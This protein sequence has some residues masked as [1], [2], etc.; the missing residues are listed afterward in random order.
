YYQPP[1]PPPPP[2]HPAIGGSSMFSVS[3][4]KF[5]GSPTG[6]HPLYRGIRPR[7][8]KWVSEIREPKK[9]T[10]IWLGTWA[11]AEMAAAAYDAAALALKGTEAILNFPQDALRYPVPP[12]S[13]AADIRKAAATA[14]A[15]KQDKEKNSSTTTNADDLGLERVGKQG[16]E[17]EFIDIEAFF[18][19]PNLLVDMAG[20]MMVSPPRMSSTDDRDSPEN[21]DC[22]GEAGSLWSYD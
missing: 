19:M 2:P 20:G 15:M 10:R 3:P 18:N 9:T 13:S 5:I 6:K 7:G 11:T 12:S 14:A 22:I 21:D 4:P 1:L 8:G 16:A 17:E